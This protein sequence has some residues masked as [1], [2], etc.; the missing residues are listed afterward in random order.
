MVKNKAMLVTC[1]CY[2]ITM[3]LQKKHKFSS[4][5]YVFPVFPNIHLPECKFYVKEKEHPGYGE[6]T[7][8]RMKA[9]L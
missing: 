8:Q 6:T 4:R 3:G 9:I 5:T 2:A 7:T 1:H